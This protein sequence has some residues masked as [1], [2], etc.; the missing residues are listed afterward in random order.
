MNYALQYIASKK[1]NIA[2]IRLPNMMREDCASGS[3]M[4]FLSTSPTMYAGIWSDRVSSYFPLSIYAI[5]TFFDKMFY[6][7]HLVTCANFGWT[8]YC[9]SSIPALGFVNKKTSSWFQNL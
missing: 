3:T 7:K 8:D 2:E 6:R 4:A 5:D 1:P 9:F